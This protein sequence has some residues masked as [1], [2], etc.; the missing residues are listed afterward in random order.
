V[1]WEN[2]WGRILAAAVSYT[3][4]G[5]FLILALVG[6]SGAVD[7]SGARAWVYLLFLLSLLGVGLYAWRGARRA[8][9]A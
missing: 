4:F 2:D 5:A 1:V 7:W 6:Y 3:F 8:S 9:L